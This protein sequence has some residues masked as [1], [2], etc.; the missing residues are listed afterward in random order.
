M[1]GH[2]FD[3]FSIGRGAVGLVPFYGT[4]F[5]ILVVWIRS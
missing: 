2:I 1:N 3:F 4:F 5:P